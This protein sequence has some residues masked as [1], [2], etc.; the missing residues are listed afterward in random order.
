MNLS[1]KL[2]SEL[3]KTRVD[4]QDFEQ[5]LFTIIVTECT[6]A[7]IFLEDR[8][9]L[10]ERI[11]DHEYLEGIYCIYTDGIIDFYD[12]QQNHLLSYHFDL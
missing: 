10:K 8:D 4:L 1:E 11:G 5:S 2:H 6:D 9:E 12:S 7:E 3:I